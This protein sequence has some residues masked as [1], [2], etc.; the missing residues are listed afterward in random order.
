MRVETLVVNPQAF[1]EQPEDRFKVWPTNRDRAPFNAVMAAERPGRTS[2]FVTASRLL[3]AHEY[4][5]GGRGSGCTLKVRTFR[6]V[7]PPSSGPCARL[8]QMVVIDLTADENAQEIFETLNARGAQLTAADLIKNFVFQRLCGSG[9][10]IETAY[11]ELLEGIR[12][13]ILGD[14]GQLGRLRYSRSSI[15]LNHWL[16]AH[17]GEEILSREV[18][19]RFKSYADFESGISMAELLGQVSRAGRVYRNFVSA[20]AQLTGPVDRLGLFAY[21]STR[22]G[23]R[24]RQAARAVPTRSGRGGN[25][26]GPSS[27]RHFKSWRAGW[28]AGCSYAPR[29]SPTLRSSRS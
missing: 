8:M 18:F 28:F 24:G 3:Q 22:H 5:A 27:S 29:A 23:E 25:P 14:G 19:Y 10:D 26:G 13:R 15:F 9:V 17:T 11:E 7:R 2:T 6:R 21:R 16:I 4:F 12:N 1:W 20:A